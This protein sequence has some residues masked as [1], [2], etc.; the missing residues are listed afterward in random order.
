M[1]IEITRAEF[2]EGDKDNV[3][4]YL[5]RVKGIIS[6]FEIVKIEDDPTRLVRIITI[7]DLDEIERG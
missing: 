4:M 1:K 7:K 6:P 2:I 3:Y 5:L